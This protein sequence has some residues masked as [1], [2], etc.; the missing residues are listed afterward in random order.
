MLS[1][2]SP[3]DGLRPA[4]KLYYGFILVK[5]NEIIILIMTIQK[6][7]IFWENFNKAD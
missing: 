7:A 4:M 3:A 2:I 5:K 6:T 1:P